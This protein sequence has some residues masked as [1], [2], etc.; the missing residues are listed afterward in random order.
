MEVVIEGIWDEIAVR[1]TGLAAS[2]KRVKL[3]IPDEISETLLESDNAA[4]IAVLRSWI[5]EDKAMTL[6]EREEAQRE[7]AEIEGGLLRARDCRLRS[8][9]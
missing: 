5:E 9:P 2:G 1:A 4:A 8:T 6:E 7:W 3:I